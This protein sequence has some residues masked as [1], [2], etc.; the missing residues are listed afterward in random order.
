MCASIRTGF[1]R[2]EIIIKFLHRSLLD[3]H[4]NKY[5]DRQNKLPI[6]TYLLSIISYSINVWSHKSEYFPI[7][8]CSDICTIMSLHG[9]T[10]EQIFHKCLQS[11]HKCV[12]WNQTIYLWNTRIQHIICVRG[13][14]SCAHQAYIVRKLTNFTQHT[15][16]LP[17]LPTSLADFWDDYFYLSSFIFVKKCSTGKIIG[18]NIIFIHTKNY[19]TKAKKLRS[20]K[21]IREIIPDNVQSGIELHRYLLVFD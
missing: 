14:P 13:I 15:S 3:R 8:E 20:L 4:E 7:K 5:S 9:L 10:F 11:P 1:V 12:N 19:I 2:L 16:W 6:T 18:V 17:Q 21:C